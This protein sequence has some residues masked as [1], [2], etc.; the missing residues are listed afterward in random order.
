MK[1]KTAGTGLGKTVS[2]YI[3]ETEKNLRKAFGRAERKTVL[4]LNDES[5]A[6]FGKKKGARGPKPD[7]KAARAE[8]PVKRR[9]THTKR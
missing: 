9:K 7:K 3:G 6:L 5:D 4:L 8:V 2:K 1:R